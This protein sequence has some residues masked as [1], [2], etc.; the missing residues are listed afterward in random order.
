MGETVSSEK[1]VKS[2]GNEND[3]AELAAPPKKVTEGKCNRKDDGDKSVPPNK[4]TKAEKKNEPLQKDKPPSKKG[5]EY[6]LASELWQLKR[7]SSQ[8]HH[9]LRT[10]KKLKGDFDSSLPR[11]TVDRKANIAKNTIEDKPMNKNIDEALDKAT[12]SCSLG[13]YLYDLHSSS[14]KKPKRKYLCKKKPMSYI[15]LQSA[16]RFFLN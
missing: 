13:T 7:K 11:I 9:Q 14:N 16:S 12:N 2:Q 1:S 4:Q 15:Y 5:E 8:C 10:N 6:S 3:E